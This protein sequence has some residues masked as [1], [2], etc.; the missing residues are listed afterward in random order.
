M[1][2]IDDINRAAVTRSPARSTSENPQTGMPLVGPSTSTL[3]QAQA[4]AR[5]KGAHQRFVDDILPAIYR[6]GLEQWRAN[7]GRSINPAIV[8]AQSAKE[9]GWGRFSGVLSPDF[10]N[11]AGIKTGRG[12]GDYDPDAHQRFDSWDEGARAHW[13]HLAAYTGLALVGDPHPRYHTVSRMPWAGTITTVEQLG[14]R[15]APAGSYGTDIVRMVNELAGAAAPVPSPEPEPARES[16]PPRVISAPN[17][18]ALPLLRRGATG[19]EV[20]K[21][22]RKLGITTDGV[23]GPITERALREFQ[24]KNSLAVDGIVGPLTWARLAR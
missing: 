13:N 1:S 24:R 23:F 6:A 3:A 10:N 15:W 17:P 12:G 21:L 7:E 20:R 9:T 18:A 4:W 8:A 16:A 22:Q 5:S 19:A 14:A 11:T 2:S